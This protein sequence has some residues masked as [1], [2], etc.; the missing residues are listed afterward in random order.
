MRP[1]WQADMKNLV[2]LHSAAALK[3]NA[4]P[5]VGLPHE[6]RW[7]LE[8]RSIAVHLPPCVPRGTIQIPQLQLPLMH[9]HMWVA[10]PVAITGPGLGCGAVAAEAQGI[11]PCSP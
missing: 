7:P 6:V 5:Q 3:R 10:V 11:G 9:E 8:S 4:L 1:T 2:L